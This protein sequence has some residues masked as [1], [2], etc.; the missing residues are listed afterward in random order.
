MTNTSG[1]PLRAPNDVSTEALFASI[2][3]TDGEG[4]ERPVRPFAIV[5]EHAKMSELEPGESVSASTKVFWSTAGFALRAAR[6]VSRQRGGVV[7]GAGRRGGRA[8]RRR[9]VRRLSDERRRQPRGRSRD[10]RRRGQVGGARWRGL[11]PRRGMSPAAGAR[12][13]AAPGARAAGAGD[14]AAGTGVLGGFADL[15]PDRNKLA[16]LRPEL[17]AD[18][19]GS[20]APG[21]ARA[22]AP[23]APNAR[24]RRRVAPNERG[25]NLCPLQGSRFDHLCRSED[26]HEPT[27][28]HDCISLRKLWTSI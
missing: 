5:C 10:A 19:S 28:R 2:T 4:R 11:S 18:A 17:T 27:R 1:V 14:S 20:T 8:G 21:P 6:P 13:A 22:A 9:R 24:P 15:L 26:W 3:V 7:V 25:N 12:S 16:R 23:G